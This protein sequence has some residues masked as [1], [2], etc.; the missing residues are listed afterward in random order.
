[1]GLIN[2]INDGSVLSSIP[3]GSSRKPPYTIPAPGTGFPKPVKCSRQLDMS[4]VKIFEV[5]GKKINVKGRKQRF[6]HK[7]T[8]NVK[9]RAATD[10]Y[11]NY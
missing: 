1:M 11:F 6:Y 5:K 4:T 2:D 7:P 3:G 8:S 9:Y 10:D